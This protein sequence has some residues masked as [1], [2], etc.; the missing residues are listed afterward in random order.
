MTFSIFFSSSNMPHTCNNVMNLFSDITSV[1][2][3][4]KVSMMSY[5]VSVELL[6]LF[7]IQFGQ[8][9]LKKTTNVSNGL[10]KNIFDNFNDIYVEPM[11]SEVKSS[12]TNSICRMLRVL[13]NS[14]KET[15][16]SSI[17]LSISPSL[18]M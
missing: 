11:L 15:T 12:L 2:C 18:Y 16:V 10:T 4:K 5:P 14:P 9:H 1:V 17:V 6:Q 7:P 13:D 8:D 3:Y